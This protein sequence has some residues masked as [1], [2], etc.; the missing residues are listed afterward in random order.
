MASSKSTKENNKLIYEAIRKI[1]AGRGY[2]RMNMAKTGTDGLGTARMIHGYVAKVHDNPNDSEYEEYAGTIDVGEFP[3]ETASP[4][5]ILHKGVMLC[6]LKHNASGFLIIPTLYSDVTIVS[7]AAT[8]YKYVMNYS[9]ADIIQIDPHTEASIG[10][11]ETEKMDIEDADSP[12]YDE[13]EKTGRYS[14]TTY[15][16]LEII[17]IV[18]DKRNKVWSKE[19]WGAKSIVREVGNSK[20]NQ[21][22]GMIEYG[23]GDLSVLIKNGKIYIGGSSATEPVVLGNQ[24]ANLMLEF[25]TECSKITTT[26][27]LGTMPALNMA[28]FSALTSKIESFKSKTVFTK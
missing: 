13:L 14:K 24:L 11:S 4:E 28:A 10:S 27:M 25:I 9:H 22:S 7:D 6:G 21:E 19:T 3:D 26:T 1:A 5:P 8:H 17:S 16:P 20:I 18:E 15:T 2:E 23:V 12:D